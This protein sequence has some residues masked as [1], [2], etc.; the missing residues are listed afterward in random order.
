MKRFIWMALTSLLPVLGFGQTTLQTVD[1]ETTSG[2]TVEGGQTTT[3]DDWWERATSAQ[4]NPVNPFSGCQGSYFFYAEDT[5]NGRT[6]D[7]PAYCTLTT[8]N[9]SSYTNL[10]IKILVAGKNDPG[11]AYEREEYLRIQYAFDGGAFTTRAQFIAA[12][13]DDTYMSEDANAD[14]VADGPALSPAF[15]EFTYSIPSAGSNLQIRIMGSTDQAGEEFGF[16]NIR[17]SGTL[18]PTETPPTVA[19]VAAASIAATSATL[20]G[21]VT[22]DGGAA[23]SARGVVVSLS[24]ANTDP[25]IGG[26]GVTQV[27]IGNGTGSFSQSVGSLSRGASYHFNAYAINSAG[28]NYGSVRSF[29]TLV[30][31]MGLAGNGNAIASGAA[32]SLA[33]GT[34]FAS[35]R[36]G[37]SWTN[38]FAITNS[39]TDAL[40]ISG[41]GIS[42]ARFEVAGMPATVA[43]GGVGQFTVRF[44]PDAV[45]SFAGVLTISNDSPTAAYVVNLAGSCFTSSTN[46]GPY[47]GGNA[48]TFTNGNFG[49]ITNVLVGGVAATI[50]DS[51]TSWFTIEMPGT[52]AEGVVDVVVQTSDEGETVLAGAYRYNPAGWIIDSEIM[53]DWSRWG[54]VEGMPGALRS[55]GADVLNGKIHVGGGQAAAIVTNFCAYDGTNWQ[56]L[57]QFPAVRRNVA[58]AVL[59]GT[60]YSMGGQSAAGA[61]ANVYAFNGTSWSSSV[62][63]PAARSRL[64]AATLDG[65]IYAVGG[66]SSTTAGTGMQTNVYAFDGTNWTE[67]AGLPMALEGMAVE[68]LNGALYSMGGTTNGVTNVFRFDG[69]GWTEVAGMPQPR[70]YMGSAVMDGK[71]YAVGGMYLW[72]RTN[73]YAFDGTNWTETASLPA[74]RRN[75]AAAELDG[76][77]YAIGGDTTYT[78]LTNVFVYPGTET[79][80]G[81]MPSSGAWTGGYS[82]VITGTNFGN[83]SD[84]TNVTLCGVRATITNQTDRRVWVLA[85][86]GAAGVGDVVV[87]SASYGTTVKSNAFEYLRSA[88]APLTFAPASPQAHASTNG[89]SVS[90]GSGTGAVSYAVT[91]GP[92]TIV[93]D[94]NLAVTA[95]S[96]TITVVAT[97]AQ[98]DHY[99]ARSA[100]ATVTC[101]KADQSIAGFLPTNGS[102]F[103]T[104]DAAGL[105]A[106]A[107]S[108]LAVTFAVGSGP[109]SIAGGTNLTFT[110]AGSVEVVASQAG[111]ANWNGAANV[112][113]SF[114]VEKAAVTVFLGGLSQ[115]YDGTARTVTA[116]TMP[117]GLT[118]EI[119]YDGAAEA[120]TNVGTYAVTG[121]V[122]DVVYQG[123]ATGA[124]EV[125][126]ASQ[127]ITFSAIGNQFWTNRL[128]LAAT[129]SSGLG[130]SF[131]VASGPATITGGTNLEF[132]GYGEVRIAASQAG[133]GNW[134]AAPAVTNAFNVLGPEF[135]LLGTN[136]AAIAH[137]NAPSAADGT[138]LGEI[139]VGQGTL[140][141]TFSLTNSGTGPLTISG[142]VTN[143]SSVFTLLNPPSVISASSVAAFS[144]VF[145]PQGGRQD[146]S[147]TFTHNATNPP[148]L[149]NVTAM[150]LGG[151]I[152]LETNAL[153]F[154]ATYVGTNP[155]AQTV[156][157]TNV[158]VSG[159]TYT[160]VITYS[161]GAAGWLAA[162][163]SAGT[164]ALGGAVTLTNLVDITGLNAGTHS[165]TVA[166][167]AADATNSPQTYVVTLTVARAAQGITFSAIADQLTTNVTLISATSTS[168]LPVMLTVM[169]GPATLSA[170]AM[171]RRAPGGTASPADARYSASGTVAIRA[172][173]VGNSNWLA[174]TTLTNTYEVYKTPQ[175]ALTFAPA[176]PQTFGTTNVLSTTGGSG[177]GV[178]SYAVSAGMGAI[179]GTNGLHATTGTGDVTVVATKATDTMY[180]PTAA[181]ATV[182]YAKADQTIAFA[183]IGNQFWTNRLA[184]AATA[185]SGLGVSFTVASGPASIAG[186][187]NLSFSGYGEVVLHADQVGDSRYNAAPTA[188][189]TFTA[190]GPQFIL[191]G[192][193]GAVVAHSNATSAADGTDL[194]EII[195]GQGTLTNTFSLTNSGTAALTLSGI[196]TNG[197]AAFSILNPPSVISAGSVATFSVVFTPQGGHQDASFTFTHD[198]TNPPFLFNVT[199]MGLGGGIAL[200]TNALSF[201]ATYVGTNPAAQTVAMTNVG[202]SGF[203]Y[204]NVITYSAGA[205]GWL[206]AVP[207]A[208][209]VAL[210]GAVTLTNLVDITG[211]NAGTHSATVAVTAVEA[212]NSPQSYVVTLVV[213]QASQG[214][215]FPSIAD[216]LTTNGVGLAATASSGLPVSF[217]VGSG[218]GSIDGSGTNL[219]F[220]GTGV[221]S[222]VASQAGNGNYNAAPDVTNTFNVAVVNHAPAGTSNT[223]TTLEDTPYNFSMADL[224]F[225]DPDDI[226]SNHFLAVKIT[227]LPAAGTLSSGG[228]AVTNGQT[229]GLRAGV[230]WTARE[231]SRWWPSVASSAD[232]TKLV[233]VENS[234]QIYTSTDSGTNWTAYESSRQWQSVA[235]SADGTKLVAVE[236]GGQ[237]YTSTDSG[238]NW[239]ARESSR[240]WRAVASSADGTKLVAAVFGGQIYT[241]TDSGTNWTARENSRW[242]TSVASSADGTKL[243]A[244]G[245]R[246]P[247]LY[248]S[249]DSGTNWTARGGFSWEAMASSA[250]GTKLVARCAGQLYTSTDSGTNWT[251]R[252]S[253]RIWTSVASSADGSQLVAAAQ[254]GQLYTSTDSGATWAARESNRQWQSVASSADGMNLVAAEWGGRIY[255]S[256]IEVDLTFTPDANGNG[257][258][259]SSF[260]FQVQDDGGTANGGVDLDPTPKVM[261][262]NVTG[263]PDDQT[264]DFPVIGDKV[265][266]DAV[267]LSATA[268]SGLPV[269]FTNLP[270][271]PVEWMSATTLTF[272]ATGTVQIVAT[273]EGNVD[274]LAAPP[275]TNTF[276][277][278]RPRELS[279]T[280]TNPVVR[281]CVSTVTLAVTNLGSEAMA[282]AA[283]ESVPWLAI[284]AG[285]SGT[286][287]GTI[288]ITTEMN[289]GAARTGTVTVTAAGAVG[290]P[291]DVTVTQQARWDFGHEDLGVGGWRR[292]AWFGD[293]VPMGEFGNNGGWIWHNQHGYYYVAGDSSPEEAWMWASDM[294]WVYTGE[295]LYPFLNRDN[296]AAWLWFNGA[297]NPRWFYNF[298]LAEWEWWP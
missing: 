251:A 183:P 196:V 164:V 77:L 141:N 182:A 74:A 278:V 287:A 20:G 193:N 187:T 50:V 59:N 203:T 242:W 188:T 153:S 285:G 13:V 190:L 228:I 107:G 6:N 110:G 155:A 276:E 60:L 244:G 171:G 1:F 157:M 99:F 275:V 184:L 211:I 162:V 181:T 154:A 109:G 264:I 82:V 48:V 195:V 220:T 296:D 295:T 113:N 255:T 89:L 166:V 243:V 19:S 103:V 216:Q 132:T 168:G 120:P 87:Q 291:V 178:V 129:A 9:V 93:G 21:E 147:F 140:T 96:G 35:L 22:A 248:I 235:S 145:T 256:Q 71:I 143:G 76:H 268:S 209:T 277:V 259:Y 16:D 12:N 226:P 25:R 5:D 61:Y 258:P 136:G 173:Q 43:A 238:T 169:S 92:G 160:N 116:T 231:N 133:N 123:V 49:N 57:A 126:K 223:V 39:G 119:T 234:G 95:G 289:S 105:S 249:T 246:G 159:F 102:A 28:T 236:N 271:S 47:A 139:I 152:A 37:S 212:T 69:T 261:T 115:T 194:G 54:E 156:A 179:V 229:V 104:T 117:A 24:S 221:V 210:G 257:S 137:G 124:L 58:F 3:P 250:D 151:G 192:T 26:T 53:T 108:G 44:A 163:P 148:F 297:T 63:L 18:A 32:A 239:T 15:A 170:H 14:G 167:T 206:A 34:K 90:G 241:S 191:L 36:T 273:Q 176:T 27:S 66:S 292:L 31:G 227:T 272:T 125:A 98:D 46:A 81:V 38:T 97:K 142:I 75:L 146:A 290:N 214:I 294:E 279:V 7:E 130:V 198:A 112:T 150:G 114:T 217:I 286:N 280:P 175:A 79:V 177:S 128:G 45:G 230:N 41:F 237:I 85:A 165:A 207:S 144:V 225:T 62:S 40:S 288:T 11:S 78:S 282:Y 252:G 274:Y 52:G 56:N 260:T 270:G 83:G 254:G 233:A 263:V 208:G 269:S 29:T 86:P 199:A 33:S 70:T 111:D 186:G 215:T 201:A 94:T 265:T 149:F 118:V 84:I 281:P 100:T 253:A 204:T 197:S 138:D 30:P 8:T 131:A 91:A 23:V 17:V 283:A 245:R 222:I 101:V 232:G 202:V 205:A 55:M 64:G 247:Q 51:G 42:D 73:V 189:N 135:V 262:I 72:A 4:V 65:K 68:A 218:P 121:T 80:T 185:S 158:G 200:E 67:V 174:A 127:T 224:G 266:T 213:A 298:S 293:Y 284:T 134:D 267:G 240:G 122:N 2:Y 106:S 219:T 88:Q 180:L 161:A 172:M 10:Q